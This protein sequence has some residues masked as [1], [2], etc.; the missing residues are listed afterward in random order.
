M[1]IQLVTKP[2]LDPRTSYKV[3]PIF[4]GE[5]LDTT[6]KLTQSFLK[7]NPK[8]GKNLESQLIYSGDQK[9]L[10]LGIGKREKL[11]FSTLEHWVGTAIKSLLKKTKE[12]VLYIPRT[13]KLSSY[14]VGQAIAL[15]V[16]IASADFAK[17]YK[18]EKD[19]VKLTNIEV[20]VERAEN[21]FLSGLKIGQVIAE[22]INLARKLS[23]MPPN[24]MTPTYF[25]NTAKKIARESK[26]KLTS[27]DEKQAKKKGM[28]AF[29]GVAQGS[30]EPSYMITL[31]YKG[32]LRTKDKWAFVGKGITFD[33]GGL[34]LKPPQH[35]T[36]MKY[37]MCGAAA[38]LATMQIIAKLK[39]KVNVVG[40]MAVTENLIGGK[41]QRPGDIVKTYSGKTAEVLNTDAEGRLVLVDALTYAQKDFKATKLVDLATLTGGMIVALGDFYTG[42]FGNNPKFTQEFIS[43]GS[44]LGEKY[45]EMPM[46]EVYNEMIKS[47]FAD[48]RNMGKG[49]SIPSAASSIVGAKFIESVV[50]NNRPWI[51][52][53]IAGTA[54]DLKSKPYGGVGATGIGV[55]TLVGLLLV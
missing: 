21:G 4:E 22:G 54:W 39:L 17:D 41:A 1:R 28:G 26:L 44:Q 13:D 7:E 45:W 40:I 48:I 2:S 35:M 52:L 36:D 37:D 12:A 16:E 5:N 11:D 27:L 24:E 43:T 34:S 55:R 32:D 29:V 33:S 6:D 50:E 10:L 3:T 49:G 46:D 30:E 51:H 8:F 14:Q 23:D 20:V 42:V 25:L 47:D 38:V 15:G 53:D 31:E 19:P 18:S 9:V